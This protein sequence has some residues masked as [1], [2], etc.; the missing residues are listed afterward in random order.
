MIITCNKCKTKFKV[1]DSLIPAEGKKV[2][3]SCCNEIWTQQSKS[4]LSSKSGLWIF[5]IITFTITFSII[6]IGLIIIFGNQIP[7]PE[8]LQLFLQ[9]IGVPVDGGELFGRS[10]KR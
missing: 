7:I 5:W 9:S 10:F 4:E 3:C 2:Q 6:Y 8:K 1:L